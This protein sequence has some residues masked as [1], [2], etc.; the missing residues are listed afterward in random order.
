MH[1]LPNETKNPAHIHSKP[2]TVW[3]HPRSHTNTS[4]LGVG[5]SCKQPQTG[6]TDSQ[7]ISHSWFEGIPSSP[8]GQTVIT[9]HTVSSQCTRMIAYEKNQQTG[10]QVSMWGELWEDQCEMA[11]SCSQGMGGRGAWTHEPV[12]KDGE[13]TGTVKTKLF[14]ST[15]VAEY[16][17]WCYTVVIHSS[18]HLCQHMIQGP[19]SLFLMGY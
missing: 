11:P 19:L 12:Q 4:L 13:A 1:P 7:G 8:P 16:V 9:H 6:S 18:C 5:F 14:F 3:F 17:L 2:A 15:S 10:R